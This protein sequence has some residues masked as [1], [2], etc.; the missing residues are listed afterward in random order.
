MAWIQNTGFV[1]RFLHLNDML[2]LLT[3]N[4]IVIYS[5]S[6]KSLH[7]D[8]ETAVKQHIKAKE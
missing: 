7:T 6:Q 3:T 2:D 8:Q 5:S 4:N 1:A